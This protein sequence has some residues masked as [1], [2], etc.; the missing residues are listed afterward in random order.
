MD[1]GKLVEFDHAHRL[2]QDSNGF[3]TKL[4][5]ETGPTEAHFLKEIAQLSYERKFKQIIK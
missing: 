2:L 5:N 3:L 1:A 4:V